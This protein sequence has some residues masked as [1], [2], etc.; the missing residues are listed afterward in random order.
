MEAIE[1]LEYSVLSLHHVGPGYQIQVFWLGS[2]HLYLLDSNY[3]FY[4]M[5]RVPHRLIWNLLHSSS[6]PLLVSGLYNCSN[7]FHTCLISLSGHLAVLQDSKS[8]LF[9][10]LAEGSSSGSFRK[11][12]LIYVRL[13]SS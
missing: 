1:H 11:L 3:F 12:R 9:L 2:K 7:L 4:I 13:N 10:T 6:W 8:H 5:N